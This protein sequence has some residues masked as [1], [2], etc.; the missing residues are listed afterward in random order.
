MQPEVRG[1]VYGATNTWET[2]PKAG[3]TF[4][5]Y[6]DLHRKRRSARVSCVVTGGSRHDRRQQGDGGDGGGGA[7]PRTLLNAPL[8]CRNKCQPRKKTPKIKTIFA[9]AKSFRHFPSEVLL[10]DISPISA[11]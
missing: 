5:K 7:G 9:S 8:S 4:T 11:A 1:R 3:K 10:Q 6:I 2:Q